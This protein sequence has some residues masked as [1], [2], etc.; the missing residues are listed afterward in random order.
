MKPVDQTITGRNGNC[1][2]A[3]LASIFELPLEECPSAHTHWEDVRAWLRNRGLAMMT[4]LVVGRE[5]DGIPDVYHII[6]GIGGGGFG[7]AVVGRGGKMVH[8]PHPSRAGLL[9]VED[10]TFFLRIGVP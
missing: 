5:S 9:E 4:I 10:F 2:A 1:V 3:C 7:H 6:G 8:D